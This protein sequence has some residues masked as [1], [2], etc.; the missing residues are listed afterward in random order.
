M[1]FINRQLRAARGN[2]MVSGSVRDAAGAFIGMNALIRRAA[3]REPV[4]LLRVDS[5][6]AELIHDD[7]R[8]VDLLRV[9]PESAMPA[10]SAFRLDPPEPSQPGGPVDLLRVSP[11]KPVD[12]SAFEGMNQLIRGARQPRT[13]G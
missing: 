3:G 6:G 7:S 9:E 2:R 8:N 4:D 13:E 12:A 1:D 10:D 11:E 5:T